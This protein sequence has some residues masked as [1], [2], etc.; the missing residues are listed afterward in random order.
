MGLAVGDHVTCETRIQRDRAPRAA[1]IAFENDTGEA[2]DLEALAALGGAYR[3]A[4][5]KAHPRIE[6][7]E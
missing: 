2:I 4:W 3:D 7:A 5:E 6:S 1:S